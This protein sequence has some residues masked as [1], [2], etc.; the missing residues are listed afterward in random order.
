MEFKRTYNYNYKKFFHLIFFFVLCVCVCLV[1]PKRMPKLSAEHEM[2]GDGTI[3]R[4]WQHQ[5]FTRF[6][7]SASEINFRIS[8]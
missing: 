5:R 2:L 3:N 8:R 7:P 6:F 1:M 4:L